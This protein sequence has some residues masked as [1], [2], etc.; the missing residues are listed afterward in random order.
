MVCGEITEK[1]ICTKCNDKGYYPYYIEGSPDIYGIRKCNCSSRLEAEAKLKRS[2]LSVLIENCT[3]ERFICGEDWQRN[4][5][6]KALQFSRDFDSKWFYI[7]GASGS[8]K[9]HICTAIAGKVLK[10]NVEL[11]Y[12]LWRENVSKI[13][14]GR[15][16][17]EKRQE[18]VEHLKRVPVLY[19][20]DLYKHR[21]GEP[22]TNPEF[23]LCFDILNHRYINK[24][25]TIIS[26][27]FTR[28]ELYA[29]DEALCTR[30]DAMTGE[31]YSI[32]INKSPDRNYR[33]TGV[34][35]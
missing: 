32:S 19:I 5:K 18:I 25:T 31:I 16:D 3:F 29:I 11:K 17:Y 23:D 30:M 22:P 34:T 6:T 20:D 1:T 9:T 4:I 12:M 14:F 10:Q 28:D 2:G 8:G 15:M 7:G 13:I 26:S 33:L 27:E 24:L 35:T 21:S